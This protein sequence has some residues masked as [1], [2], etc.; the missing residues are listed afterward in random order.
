MVMNT[1]YR[2]RGDGNYECKICGKIF[3]SVKAVY[4]HQRVHKTDPNSVTT[5]VDNQPQGT[6]KRAIAAMTVGSSLDFEEIEKENLTLDE[7]EVAEALLILQYGFDTPVGVCSSSTASDSSDPPIPVD[8][9]NLK[10]EGNAKIDPQAKQKEGCLGTPIT[11]GNTNNDGNSTGSSGDG[12]GSRVCQCP[13]C[14]KTFS[15]QQALGGHMAGHN[16]MDRKAAAVAEGG[17]SSAAQVNRE[18]KCVICG[19]TFSSGQ[20]LGG[21]MTKHF[22]EKKKVVVNVGNNQP[23]TTH[24][25]NQKDTTSIIVTVELR[26]EIT[27][28]VNEDGAAGIAKKEVADD[29]IM[30]DVHGS[31]DR[32][33]LHL[34]LNLNLEPI[35]VDHD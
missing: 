27:M 13:R 22:L 3:S 2:A 30:E 23:E 1:C 14:P 20:A 15:T 24:A 6:L 4:G 35:D 25:D 31:N 11:V 17:A 10:T 9:E 28:V 5:R 19:A 32:K 12:D 7:L 34:M 33:R 8:Q 16:N 18:H 21:H 26:K 29:V